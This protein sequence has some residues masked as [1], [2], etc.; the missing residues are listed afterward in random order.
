MKG[1]SVFLVV[2]GV[3]VL[4]FAG[5]IFLKRRNVSAPAPTT[6]VASSPAVL[7]APPASNVFDVLGLFATAAGGAATAA[8]N[9]GLFDPTKPAPKPTA[10]AASTPTATAAPT[11]ST[12]I[13]ALFSSPAYH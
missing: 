5:F 3:A 4:G 8:V 13:S 2:G 6:S 12:S 7:T 10:G 9:R 1:S 11:A